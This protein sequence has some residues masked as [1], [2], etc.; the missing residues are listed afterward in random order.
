MNS[1]KSILSIVLIAGFVAA[2]T[3]CS[4]N[5]DPLPVVATTFTNLAADPGTGFNPSNGQPTGLTRQFTFFSFKTGDIVAHADSATN[6]WDL[7]FNGTTIIVN[8]ATSGLGTSQAQIVSGIFDELAIAPT[9]G[10]KSDND[11]API[12]GAPNANLAIPTGSGQ[13]WYTYDGVNMVNK[14]TAGKIIVVKTSEGR[15][16]KMEILSYY[17]DAPA[18]PTFNNTARYYTFRYVYQPNE[19]TSFN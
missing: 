11:V 2:F 1:V 17:K 15:Y 9:D 7:G 13:G 5:E 10:Y 12:A 14:P 8:S 3:G 6:K 4:E 18:N 16:A 19:T